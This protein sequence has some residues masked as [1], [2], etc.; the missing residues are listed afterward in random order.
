MRGLNNHQVQL[1]PGRPDGGA[2][3]TRPSLLPSLLPPE[4]E[5]SVGL[6]ATA[7]PPRP[8]QP[9]HGV[10]GGVLPAHPPSNSRV[11]FSQKDKITKK[12]EITTHLTLLHNGEPIGSHG[13]T[14]THT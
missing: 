6:L 11:Q 4:N 9:F 13:C 14:K 7:C 2:A 5:G 10:G 3:S 8:L 12:V 1:I